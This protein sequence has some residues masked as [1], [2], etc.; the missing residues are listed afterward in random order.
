LRNRTKQLEN[1]KKIFDIYTLLLELKSHVEQIS[2][3]YPTSTTVCIDEDEDDD[4]EKPSHTASHHHI[5][6]PRASPKAK[7]MYSSTNTGITKAPSRSDYIG[8]DVV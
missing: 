4:D 7:T 5:I 3:G 8:S 1:S 6:I 2:Q